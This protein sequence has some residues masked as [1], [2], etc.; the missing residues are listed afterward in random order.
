LHQNKRFK[1]QIPT[2]LVRRNS[3]WHLM[4]WISVV[5]RIASLG[6]QLADVTTNERLYL[7]T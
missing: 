6:Q 3:L 2:V 7:R 5:I 1:L 4:L